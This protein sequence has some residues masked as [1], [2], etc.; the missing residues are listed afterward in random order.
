MNFKRLQHRVFIKIWYKVPSEIPN[1]FPCLYF[2]QHFPLQLQCLFLKY[3]IQSIKKH[4]ISIKRL[5]NFSNKYFEGFTEFVLNFHNSNALLL[6]SSKGYF[7]LSD[8][9]HE[10]SNFD[11]LKN[12][13]NLDHKN[14]ITNVYHYL[15]P[16][17]DITIEVLLIKIYY[18][19]QII[20]QKFQN[21]Y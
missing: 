4:F 1:W 9:I 18:W 14:N 15:H 6:L 2:L 8:F 21:S 12:V 3:V 7:W 11:R 20:F 10:A 16:I 17:F 13:T 5:L 19:T